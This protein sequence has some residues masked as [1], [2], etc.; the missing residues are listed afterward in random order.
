MKIVNVDEA[1]KE[2]INKLEGEEWTGG[3][4]TEGCGQEVCTRKD[5][6]RRFVHGMKNGQA[7]RQSLGSNRNT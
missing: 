6:D 3:L 2:S 7:D 4:Y 1:D 5:V